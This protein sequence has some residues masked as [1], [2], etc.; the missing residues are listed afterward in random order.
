MQT[1]DEIAV[2][3]TFKVPFV[4]R[5]AGLVT[6]W[7]AGKMKMKETYENSAHHLVSEVFVQGIMK[8]ECLSGDFKLEG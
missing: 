1:G 5:A 6:L 8:T 3:T 4:L 7:R 2:L